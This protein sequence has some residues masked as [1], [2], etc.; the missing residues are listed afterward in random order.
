[1]TLRALNEPVGIGVDFLS[2]I[3][4]GINA[5]SFEILEQMAAA[6]SLPVQDL[7]DFSKEPASRGRR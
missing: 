5:P 1:V 2:V 3:E 6:L 7:F 4:R